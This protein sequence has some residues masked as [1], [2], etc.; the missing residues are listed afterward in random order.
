VW[1]QPPAA[2]RANPVDISSNPAK[3]PGT[4]NFCVPAEKIKCL[5]TMENCFPVYPSFHWLRQLF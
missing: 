5:E 3:Y 2:N 4:W 1:K